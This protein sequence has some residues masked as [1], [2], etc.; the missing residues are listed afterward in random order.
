MANNIKNNELDG[1]QL[2]NKNYG[3]NANHLLYRQM[4]MRDLYMPFL[5]AFEPKDYGCVFETI[6]R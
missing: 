2:Y 4:T 3:G 1:V 5:L 6:N